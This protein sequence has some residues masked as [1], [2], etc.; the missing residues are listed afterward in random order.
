MTRIVVD[1]PAPFGPT[2][3]V[4]WP[5]RTVNVIPSSAGTAPNRLRSPATSMV[6]SMLDEARFRRGRRSSRRG[7][8]LGVVLPGD[9]P[10]VS[11]LRGTAGIP[12]PG[13]A[14]GP[15]CGDHDCMAAGWAPPIPAAPHS[16]PAVGVVLGLAAFVQS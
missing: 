8:V 7:T 12:G 14:A 3:P 6:A 16:L 13:D 9:L 11:P 4:T 5:G 2:K 10:R 1:L 15:G